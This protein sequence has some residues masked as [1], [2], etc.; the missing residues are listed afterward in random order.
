M[1]WNLTFMLTDQKDTYKRVWF[2]QGNLLKSNDK[3]HNDE[4]KHVTITMLTG[5]KH[6][7]CK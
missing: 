6:G 5:T 1:S 4:R 7:G 3:I 2:M